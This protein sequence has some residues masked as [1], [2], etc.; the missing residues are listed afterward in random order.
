M[1]RGWSWVIDL[2]QLSHPMTRSEF[3]MTY[4]Y[5]L[6]F[7]FKNDKIQKWGRIKR[8]E[9]DK[10]LLRKKYWIRFVYID[11]YG[12]QDHM[13]YSRLEQR[14]EN[15]IMVTGAEVSSFWDSISHS[16]SSLRNYRSLRAYKF[17]LYLGN[18]D[19]DIENFEPWLIELLKFPW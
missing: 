4:H 17:A 11:F 13:K 5:L 18:F 2:E 9:I 12:K 19:I 6:I 1:Y 14:M 3:L 10:K 7:I 8:G 15:Q 16:L